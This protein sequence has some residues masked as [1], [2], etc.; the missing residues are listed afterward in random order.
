ME[1]LRQQRSDIPAITHVDYTARIQ[2]VDQH[3]NPRYR[4]LLEKFK[5]KT[6]YGMLIN[7]SFN[8]KDEPI[9]CT[10]ED[11]IRCFL[12]TDMDVLVI[13]NYLLRKKLSTEKKP[14]SPH[15]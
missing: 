8:V 14:S 4:K 3:S 10:P 15:A 7:T 11:A 2:T 12:K 1:R 13:E 6:G 9:V 5:E